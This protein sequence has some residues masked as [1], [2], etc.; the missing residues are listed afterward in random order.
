MTW[1]V[2]AEDEYGEVGILEE[3]DEWRDG[4]NFLQGNIQAMIHMEEAAGEM[5]SAA[6]LI[7]IS[8]M[9]EDQAENTSS[10]WQWESDRIRTLWMN[11]RNRRPTKSEIVTDYEGDDDEEM[12]GY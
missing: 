6:Q 8:D 2:G 1:W 7:E 4:Y 11:D 9:L 10:A 12:Y 5:E 3:F